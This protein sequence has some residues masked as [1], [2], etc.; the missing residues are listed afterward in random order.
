MGGD[1]P[2]AAEQKIELGGFDLPLR[3]ALQRM[4]GQVNIIFKRFYFGSL[5]L[6]DYVL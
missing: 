2:V 6:L 4:D 3:F 1:D 5:V